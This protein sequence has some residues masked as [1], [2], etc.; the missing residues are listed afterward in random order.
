MRME[1]IELS[2]FGLYCRI[3]DFY[4][5][6]WR[7][8][9]QAVITHWHSDHACRGCRRYLAV[10]DGSAVAHLRLGG[11]VDIQTLPY[12]ES[13]LVNGVRVSLHPAGHILGSA[14]VRL[15]HKGRVW[16]VTGDVKIDTD[17]TCA[18]F[19]SIPCDTLVTESTFGLPIF[20]WQP[21]RVIFEG[22]NHWWSGN[23]AEGK[24]SVVFAYALGKAQ[25]ILAG[26]DSSVGP[27]LT[28]G[29]V[30]NMNHCYRRAGIN[31][32]PTRHVA[33]IGS[34]KQF[35][36][37]LVVAPPSADQPGWTRR[38]PDASRAFASGWMLIRG[39]RRRRSVDRGF[40]L[41]DHTDW[42][43]LLRIIKNSGA[44][45]IWVTHGYVSELVRYLRE[46]GL[47]AQ[48]MTTRYNTETD[49]TEPYR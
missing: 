23:R 49:E 32:P 42:N 29:A 45:D 28:H 48:A 25:R 19:E 10:E 22:I 34:R 8:V 27:I 4:V 41:S 15:E 16:V 31:L 20:K 37:A 14:Q 30:E 6:P 18:A 44:E 9:N 38:F 11:E 1:L 36:G 46:V 35:A 12:G 13:V 21:Q 24:T 39:H 43:G 26:L 40:A 33:E 17:P 3:G 47:N 2:E 7:P 5:D